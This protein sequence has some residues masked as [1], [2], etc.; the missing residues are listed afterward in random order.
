MYKEVCFATVSAVWQRGRQR[1]KQA[2]KNT[3]KTVFKGYV[4]YRIAQD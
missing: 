2:N 3:P 4:S 1:G